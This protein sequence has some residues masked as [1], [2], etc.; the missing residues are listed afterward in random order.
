MQPEGP[1]LLRNVQQRALPTSGQAASTAAG[2]LPTL[3]PLVS[4]QPAPTNANV[5]KEYIAACP[6]AGRC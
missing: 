5:L 6:D 4:L 2:L 1:V 3:M